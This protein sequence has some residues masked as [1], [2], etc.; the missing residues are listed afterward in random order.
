MKSLLPRSLIYSLL[1]LV[2]TSSQTAWS[3][4]TNGIYPTTIDQ[5]DAVAAWNSFKNDWL[6]SANTPDPTSMLRQY[7]QSSGVYDTRGE[8]QAWALVMAVMHD[9]HATAQKLWNFAKHYI[10]DQ[11]DG[12]VPW[13][14]EGPNAPAGSNVGDADF[15]YAIALDI[16]ARKWP[17]FRFDDSAH[18]SHLENFAN[19][20]WG[21]WA[22]YYITRIYDKSRWNLYN[23][24]RQQ[25]G[26]TLLP[27]AITGKGDNPDRQVY[28]GGYD[29]HAYLH[30][31][32][33]GFLENWE[34]RSG[35]ANWT[36]SIGS[37][38]SVYQA[39]IELQKP[40]LAKFYG[41]ASSNPFCWPPHQVRED[42]SPASDLTKKYDSGWNLFNWGPGRITHR[43]AHAYLNT[44]DAHAE[45]MLRF[46]AERFLETSGGDP[47]GV[48]TGYKMDAYLDG[49]PLGNGCN[50]W[51]DPDLFHVGHAAMAF[52]VD[53]V[54]QAELDLFSDYLNA[55]SPGSDK[56]N[57]SLGKAYYLMHL[58]GMMDYRIGIEVP[59]DTVSILYGDGFQFGASLR[60]DT[61]EVSAPTADG[62]TSAIG[63]S[64]VGGW[65]SVGFTGGPLIETGAKRLKFQLYLS[66]LGIGTSLHR[67]DLK[68]DNSAVSGGTTTE[69][70][71]FSDDVVRVNG[72]LGDAD[73]L[74]VGWND[75]EIDLMRIPAV[76]RGDTVLN[77]V[78]I[79]NHNDVKDIYID[80]IEITASGTASPPPSTDQVIYDDAVTSLMSLRDYSEV[81]D[82]T[83]S[84]SPSAL[85][86]SGV[87][88]WGTK[89]I[90]ITDVVLGS[91][92]TQLSLQV[93][94]DS[95]SKLKGLFLLTETNGNYSSATM[96]SS[97]E[98][99]STDGVDGFA[100]DTP[101][102]WHELE[103][104]LT[105]VSGYIDG[106]TKLTRLGIQNHNATADIRI[107]S[108]VLI[109]S[110]QPQ[111][112]PPAAPSNLT[113]AA[114]SQSEI[115][116]DFTDNS[117]DE[118]EFLLQQ[119]T[120]A[121][122]NWSQ[123]ITLGAGSGTGEV[124]A[125]I[126]GLAP[127]TLYTYRIASSNG[128][129]QSSFS[130]MQ[131]A[132][133][134]S[135]GQIIYDDAVTPLM[136]LLDFT[137]STAESHAASTSSLEAVSVS[138]WQTKWIDI[139]GVTIDGTNDLLRMQVYFKGS[140]D[141]L[142][143]VHALSET[144]GQFSSTGFEGV[145]EGVSTDGLDGFSVD[146]KKVWH[147][148]EVDLTRLNNFQPGLTELRK[149]GI[150]NHNSAG[151]IYID[152]IKLQ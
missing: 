148:V 119:S 102:Q 72:K 71:S 57:W 3:I 108:I 55:M 89:S 109:G 114:V 91:S 120:D 50:G 12:F 95:A 112:T 53:P 129:G 81:S 87:G 86:V 75:I 125:L 132:T 23:E 20:T 52:M 15:D 1:L 124:Q 150:Q 130:A 63:S 138:A 68:L 135:S 146:R 48:R 11:S 25:L 85:S 100:V 104:D 32:P 54:Y 9:D 123:T 147:T 128:S 117:V 141:K 42:G 59:A 126:T 84:G 66:S 97:G 131:S 43:A 140:A 133:T 151:T 2:L 47:S 8:Y 39:E 103:V 93:N 14:I 113:V 5:Q 41:D 64:G 40:T 58:T 149:I 29:Y 101:N 16:A 69:Y 34:E 30:Y 49:D 107:D 6:D 94:Y 26:M 18:E 77:G 90:N 7:W 118:T 139:N 127:G 106:T 92:A 134:Y 78:S 38:E 144:D 65:Q 19:W 46:L 4:T 105:S 143:G 98:G 116:L 22:D 17:D 76:S 56:G 152:D 96:D 45:K 67:I 74:S 73:S 121:G 82:P 24:R 13:K 136:S 61:Q 10:P 27:N 110:G 36:Q 37:L 88:A 83:H 142:K 28:S 80:E 31:S 79:R 62:S 99:I 70:L 137:E 33:Y 60:S 122:V 111:G 51:G 44:A 145:G 115:N 35:I 21:D